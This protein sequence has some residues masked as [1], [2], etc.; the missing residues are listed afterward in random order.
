MWKH[1]ELGS[2]YKLGLPSNMRRPWNIHLLTQIGTGRPLSGGE[3]MRF[4]YEGVKPMCGNEEWPQPS[5]LFGSCVSVEWW[6]PWIFGTFW[7]DVVG[8]IG[9]IQFTTPNSSPSIF[10]I[11]HV[12]TSC[13]YPDA[14]ISQ[15]ATVLASV[16]T[17]IAIRLTGR[18]SLLATRSTTVQQY[19]YNGPSN[20]WI[21][22]RKSLK[23]MYNWGDECRVYWGEK[24]HLPLGKYPLLW[25][26][27]MFN[28]GES[29]VR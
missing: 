3:S 19:N 17:A 12:V 26:I 22:G 6:Q 28:C 4:L 18:Q 24:S 13:S 23:P 27:Q 8:G 9:R 25:A 20:C 15:A 10:A 7:E 5:D 21:R 2:L 29:L 1:G 16:A 14:Y 11:W